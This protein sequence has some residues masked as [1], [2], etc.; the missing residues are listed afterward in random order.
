MNRNCH[1]PLRVY[2]HMRDFSSPFHLTEEYIAVTRA[3]VAALRRI[4]LQ[5]ILHATAEFY[6]LMCRTQK[7]ATGDFSCIL[8]SHFIPRLVAVLHFHRLQAACGAPSAISTYTQRS[9]DGSRSSSSSSSSSS[10]NSSSVF[11]STRFSRAT[12]TQSPSVATV[13]NRPRHSIFCSFFH[14]PHHHPRRFSSFSS[15]SCLLFLSSPMTRRILLVPSASTSTL[16]TSFRLISF[17]YS[18]PLPYCAPHSSP[19]P[20]FPRHAFLGIFITQLCHYSAS[21]L[22]SHNSRNFCLSD[23]P[24]SFFRCRASSERG[25][26]RKHSRCPM[27]STKFWKIIFS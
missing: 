11:L 22:N 19:P 9:R 10:I 24:P 21:S 2:S 14:F 6:E 25:F 27:P 16:Q 3:I 23:T 12:Y 15:F 18:S 26:F 13:H 17:T 1:L 5:L 20:P 8:F 4:S 7:R